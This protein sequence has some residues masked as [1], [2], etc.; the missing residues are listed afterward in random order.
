MRDFNGTETSELSVLEKLPQHRNFVQYFFHRIQE[1]TLQI[2]MK[3]YSGTLLDVIKKRKEE[4]KRFS[5][6]EIIHILHDVAS[7]LQFLHEH[8]VI[9]RGMALLHECRRKT[10]SLIQI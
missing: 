2:F 3:Q 6:S 9:H 5:P 8:N 10:N 4:N 1:H 7:G